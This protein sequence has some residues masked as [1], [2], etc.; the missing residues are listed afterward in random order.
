LTLTF[1][2]ALLE[3]PGCPGKPQNQ[4]LDGSPEVQL[5]EM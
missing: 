4:C 5:L 2:Q 3:A 1:I